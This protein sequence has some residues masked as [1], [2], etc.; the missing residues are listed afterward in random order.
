M[1]IIDPL[2]LSIKW[3]LFVLL[4]SQLCYSCMLLNINL[5]GCM[6]TEIKT[7]LRETIAWISVALMCVVQNGYLPLS[8][9]YISY[10]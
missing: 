9:L 8:H 4:N 3:A 5:N 1:C 7:N 2:T 6:M 10:A